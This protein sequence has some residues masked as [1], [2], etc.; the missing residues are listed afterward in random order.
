MAASVSDVER[1]EPTG[2][3]AGLAERDVVRGL[4]GGWNLREVARMGHLI[5]RTNAA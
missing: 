5:L 3:F 2:F 4:A 1:F